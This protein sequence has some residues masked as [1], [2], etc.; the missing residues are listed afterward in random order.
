VSLSRHRT[1]VSDRVGTSTPRHRQD[2]GKRQRLD[3]R[4]PQEEGEQEP[5]V[6]ELQHSGLFGA[7]GSDDGAPLHRDALGSDDGVDSDYG[8]AG[9]I[10]GLHG[11]VG[12]DDDVAGTTINGL[13]YRHHGLGSSSAATP[14]D[15]GKS[16]SFGQD[17]PEEEVVR[18][19]PLPRV[20][21]SGPQAERLPDESYAGRR[22]PQC[23][24][25]GQAEGRG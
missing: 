13:K 3:L 14:G 23:L 12:F 17:H 11:I 21:S 25:K 9:R 6:R 5:A 24:R 2:D 8:R 10:S 16:S 4:H 19:R 22:G 1:S 7:L 15:P 20:W 18:G